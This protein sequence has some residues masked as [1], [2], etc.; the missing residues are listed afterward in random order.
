[1]ALFLPS[2]LHGPW[3]RRSSTREGNEEAIAH[4]FE[5]A[6]KTFLGCR[7]VGKEYEALAFY[8]PR[9]PVAEYKKMAF[10]PRLSPQRG[11]FLGNRLENI[12]KTMFERYER[13]VLGASHRPSIGR[14]H[15]MQAF[16]ILKDEDAVFGPTQEGGFYLM[17]FKKLYPEI[18][19]RALW[20]IPYAFDTT[21]KILTAEGIDPHLL[22]VLME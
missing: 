12:F 16:E 10:S 11:D 19:D 9:Y 6:S 3:N 14:P 2:P 17:G 13:V 4:F 8:D 22:P 7:P 5:Q 18:F 20:K 1:M 15:F 21:F